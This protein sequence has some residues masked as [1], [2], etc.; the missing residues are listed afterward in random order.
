MSVGDPA[1]AGRRPWIRRVV[2]ALVTMALCGAAVV[3]LPGADRSDSAGATQKGPVLVAAGGDIHNIQHVVVIMQENRS[4][5]NYFGTYPGADGIPMTGSGVSQ[6]CAPSSVSATC[7]HAFLDDHDIN[8]GG[9]HGSK[10]EVADVNGGNMDGFLIQAEKG[11]SVCWDPNHP[12][13]RKGPAGDV[14]GYH[15]AGELPNYWQYAQNFVLQDK[16]F[17]SGIGWSLPSHQA[18]VSGWSA[19]CT[20]PADPMSCTSAPDAGPVP[21]DFRSQRGRSRRPPTRGPISP[22]C[23]TATACRGTTS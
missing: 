12:G 8:V 17:A 18:M 3:G 9:P 23:C 1:G 4:F 21:P 7:Q 13:C 19:S 2:A 6:V 10:D 16:M 22:G 14:M 15:D 5:D 11:L 20:N